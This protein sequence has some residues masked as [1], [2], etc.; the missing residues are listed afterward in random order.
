MLRD[1]VRGPPLR[2]RPAGAIDHIQ[3]RPVDT[4]GVKVVNSSSYPE[5]MA[6]ILSQARSDPGPTR[7]ASGLGSDA[8]GHGGSF[9]RLD[10]DHDFVSASPLAVT[11]LS[12][13]GHLPPLTSCLHTHTPRPLLPRLLL[14][15]VARL[16]G[17]LVTRPPGNMPP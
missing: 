15:L 11:P 14:R 7:V 10:V 6:S 13:P 5:N 16:W 17:R 3:M 8:G 12:T 4:L 1:G 2:L 9:Q